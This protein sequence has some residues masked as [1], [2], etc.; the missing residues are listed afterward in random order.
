[1]VDVIKVDGLSQFVRNLKKIDKDLP[2]A[3]RKS[4]NAA[5]DLLLADIKPLVP[6]RSGAAVNTVRSTSTQTAA[7]VSGGGKRA[8]YYPWLDFGGKVGRK[9]ST[10]RPFIKTGRYIYGAY[11]RDRDTGKF[12]QVM[13]ENLLDVVRSAGIE[14][15]E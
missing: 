10:V 2:K 6:V 4:F 13:V 8:P 14:V 11:Y 7:R 9:K 3:V 15:G 12:E 1:M 5:A